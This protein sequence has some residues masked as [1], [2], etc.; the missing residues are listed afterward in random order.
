MLYGAPWDCETW[1]PALP[2]LRHIHAVLSGVSSERGN[3]A[4][5]HRSCA[6][7]RNLIGH[8]AALSSQLKGTFLI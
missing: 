6:P 7:E 1:L 2:L 8:T 3:C 5:P 4:F